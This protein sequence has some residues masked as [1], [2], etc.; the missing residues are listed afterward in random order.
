[1]IIADLDKDGIKDILACGNS[2]DPDITT[3]N[4][5]AMASLFLKGKGK[6]E[7]EAISPAISGLPVQGEIRKIILLN[8]SSF[9]FLQNSA[10]AKVVAFG[11]PLTNR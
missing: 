6:G 4:L 10:K 5:D 1:M 2:Y 8:N 7:F 11:Q 3:G 9:I